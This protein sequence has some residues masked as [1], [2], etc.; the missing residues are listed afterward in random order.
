MAIEGSLVGKWS[1]DRSDDEVNKKEFYH[2]PQIK[3]PLWV[4]ANQWALAVGSNVISIKTDGQSSYFSSAKLQPFNKQVA[5]AYI[6]A[7]SERSWATFDE[8]AECYFS[9]V[10]TK[11]DKGNWRASTCSCPSF[12]RIY[13]CCHII[14]LASR[15]K[16]ITIPDDAKAV[17]LGAKRKRGRIAGMKRALVVQDNPIAQGDS[18]DSGDDVDDV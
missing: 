11:L 9:V 4:A 17:P 12:L 6:K 1:L 2:E 10:E 18:G 7:R 3:N 16:L 14:G 5:L 8:W 15:Y 13:I